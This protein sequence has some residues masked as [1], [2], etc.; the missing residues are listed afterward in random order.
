V[1]FLCCSVL[2]WLWYKGDTGFIKCVPSSSVFVFCFVLSIGIKCN[3]STFVY[4]FESS[5]FFFITLEGLSILS[6][7]KILSFHL[8]Y[9][10][11]SLYFISTLIFIISLLLLTLSSVC[12]SFLIFEV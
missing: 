1:I 4:N 7:Q 12:S 5:L 11:S 3:V 6:F 10:L 8:F 9:C 2:L